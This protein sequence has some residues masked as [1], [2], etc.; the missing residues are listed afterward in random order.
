M[1]DLEPPAVDAQTKPSG[2][3][4]QVVRWL[5]FV[6]IGSSIASLIVM[7]TLSGWLAGVH[8]G[9]AL[10]L[11]GHQPSALLTLADD[12]LERLRRRTEPAASASP[13][14]TERNRPPATDGADDNVPPAHSA[15]DLAA[16]SLAANPFGAGGFKTLALAAEHDGDIDRADEL[17]RAAA[18][19]SHSEAEALVWLLRRDFATHRYDDAALEADILMRSFPNLVPNV[20]LVLARMA[21]QP[22]TK[23]IVAK[24]LATAPPWRRGFFNSLSGAITDLRTPLNLLNDLVGT[25]APP[26]AAEINS[27]MTFLVQHRRYDVAQF[28]WLL[29]LPPEQLAKVGLLNNGNFSQPASGSPF[30]WTIQAGAGSTVDFAPLPNDTGRALVVEF[31]IGRIEFNGVHQTVVLAP[32]AYRLRGQYKGQLKGRRG[33]QWQVTCMWVS[34]YKLLKAGDMLMGSGS[35][36]WSEF[37]LDFTVPA[38]DCSA[39]LIS[40]VF[41]ARSAS[42]QLVSGSMSFADLELAKAATPQ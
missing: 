27:Y 10:V 42:E 1:S 8:P 6:L 13:T 33:L 24:L 9:G 15:A 21:E 20:T 36:A 30:D 19:R 41:A 18:K 16:A 32:G 3:P 23:A 40:L 26:T 38:N 14:A 11:N 7:H 17:M 4:A 28:T 22:E 35:A 34:G 12:E 29:F 39:Q 37:T 25:S 5:G 31:G 2:R